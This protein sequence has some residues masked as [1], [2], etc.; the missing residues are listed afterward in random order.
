MSTIPENVV[1][2]LIRDRWQSRSCNLTSH[3]P[4]LS[5]LAIASLEKKSRAAARN[6]P[7]LSRL[8]AR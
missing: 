5:H 2:D 1:P 8:S 7:G 4:S 3:Y 6:C